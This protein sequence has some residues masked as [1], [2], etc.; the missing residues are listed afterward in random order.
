MYFLI[1]YP[2][3]AL[4]LLSSHYNHPFSTSVNLFPF[5]YSQWFALFF[6]FHSVCISTVISTVFVFSD[7]YH[8]AWHPPSPS[9]L[10]LD[11]FFHPLLTSKFL[12][13][14]KTTLVWYILHLGKNAIYFVTSFFN[15][16]PCML[17][18]WIRIYIYHIHITNS[19]VSH[20]LSY[21]PGL[22]MNFCWICVKL[23]L[24]TISH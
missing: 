18:N 17:M 3:H 20:F 8:L 12:D 15:Y 19:F 11:K 5:C 16:M 2:Y 14:I 6:T 22:L 10:V 13:S 7:F 21:F 1:L 9:V 23:S 24:R 4:P